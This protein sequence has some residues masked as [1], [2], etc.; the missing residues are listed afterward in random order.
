MGIRPVS[1]LCWPEMLAFLTAALAETKIP[2]ALRT[3]PFLMQRSQL[4][5][6]M[7]AQVGWGVIIYA[8]L[9]AILRLVLLVGEGEDSKAIHKLIT[10]FLH[11]DI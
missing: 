8:N 1:R 7:N 5:K 10:V 6:Y 11:W 4:E 2:V 9:E 3:H